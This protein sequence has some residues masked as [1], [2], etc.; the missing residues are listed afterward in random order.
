MME[1]IQQQQQSGSRFRGMMEYMQ[2]EFMREKTTQ[3]NTA[4]H[5]YPEPDPE[6]KRKNKNW[7]SGCVGNYRA[8]DHTPQE[9]GGLFR[10][11]K[12]GVQKVD[13]LGIN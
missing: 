4:Q 2:R 1:Y 5:R 12:A 11:L 9:V 3:H 7:L 6:W 13:C 8:E 10:H